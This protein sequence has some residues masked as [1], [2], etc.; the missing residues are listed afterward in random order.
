M[1]KA[2]PFDRES[3]KAIY[4]SCLNF[5]ETAKA[6]PG[7]KSNTIR[8]WARRDSTWPTPTNGK[9]LIEQGKAIVRVN[10]EKAHRDIVAPVT[11]PA[12][13]MANL[14][15]NQRETFKAGMSSGLSR[16]ASLIGSMDAE[17]ILSES[18]K[19]KDILDSGA[20]LYALGQDQQGATIAVNVLSLSA[21]ALHNIR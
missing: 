3:V 9:K 20:K 2:V 11:S 5:E 16:A 1:P 17:A 10:A 8:Q 4:L 21:D 19:V 7:L 13:G 6:F 12:E 15:E 14:I 18:R